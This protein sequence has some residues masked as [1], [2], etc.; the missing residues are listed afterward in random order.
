MSVTALLLS[1]CNFY[2]QEQGFSN[3][4]KSFYYFFI[5]R[6]DFGLFFNL[7]RWMFSFF[8]TE[9]G[10]EHTRGSL[11]FFSVLSGCRNDTADTEA[12]LT[13]CLLQNDNFW[14]VLFCWLHVL[15]TRLRSEHQNCFN[16]SLRMF[17]RNN[18]YI[19]RQ[20]ES[21]SFPANSPSLA[22]LFRCFTA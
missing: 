10:R 2:Y 11:C 6:L 4:H 17:E 9:D 1:W 3:L 13:Q 15:R 19:V 5:F 21:S 20:N 22:T 16:T 7:K 12:V 18:K 14:L 8:L